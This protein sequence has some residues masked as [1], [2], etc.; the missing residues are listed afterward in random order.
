MKN[1]QKIF[2]SLFITV[3]LSLANIH[4]NEIYDISPEQPNRVHVQ[5]NDA[6][7]A[8]IPKDFRFVNPGKLTIAVAPH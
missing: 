3:P 8:A 7:I 5:K 2:A 6:A 4:A 1:I